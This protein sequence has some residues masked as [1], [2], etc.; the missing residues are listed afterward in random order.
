MIDRPA[1]KGFPMPEQIKRAV[2]RAIRATGYTIVRLP[3]IR[4]TAPERGGTAALVGAARPPAIDPKELL[5]A[6]SRT[7]TADHLAEVDKLLNAITPWRGEVPSSRMMPVELH[8]RMPSSTRSHWPWREIVFDYAPNSRHV[9]ERGSNGSRRRESYRAK[10]GGLT[11]PTNDRAA[12]APAA[13]IAYGGGRQSGT[14]RRRSTLATAKP[15]R[16]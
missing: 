15:F 12:R 2:L 6:E 14:E 11:R 3:D 16:C 7:S 8:R 4:S 13:S 5:G 9:T 10:P 1:A